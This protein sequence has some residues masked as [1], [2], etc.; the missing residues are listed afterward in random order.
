MKRI[1]SFI[2]CLTM[3]LSFA[4]I[5][6]AERYSKFTD[7]TQDS[8][9]Y[10][11][12]DNAVRLGIINGK[13]ETTF[14]PD[15]NLTY[16]EAIKLA[17]C[18][19]QLY[20]DG[21]VY[22]VSGGN[23]WYE[24]YVNYAKDHGIITDNF[25]EKVNNINEKATRAGYMEIFA[26]A[27]PDEALECIN[28]VPD[29]SIPDVPMVHESAIGIYKL[30]R[31]GILTG[32]DANHNC[33]PEDNIKRC[34]V[35]AII[36]RMMDETKRLTFS[37]GT[38][39]EEP[40]TEEPKAEEPKTEEPKLEIPKDAEF[41]PEIKEDEASIPKAETPDMYEPF[42]IAVQPTHI[43]GADEGDELKYTVKATG[44]KTPYTY[45]WVSRGWHNQTTAINDSE[46]AKGTKTNTLTMIFDIDNLSSSQFR[47]EV[48]DALGQKVQSDYIEL[49]EKIFIFSPE[50]VTSY[51]GG[52]IFAG[53][54]S[55]GS[56]RAGETVAISLPGE[57]IQ[58][59]GVATKLEM[60]K[61]SIDEVEEGNYCGILIQELE[62][63]PFEG[64]IEESYS[65]AMTEYIEGLGNYGVKIP[66]TVVECH[67]PAYTKGKP[68]V[69]Y[70]QVRGGTPPYTYEWYMREGNGEE[71]KVVN[72]A[73][74]TVDGKDL[75]I[76]EDENEY[77]NDVN[78]RCVITDAAGNSE[79][80]RNWRIYSGTTPYI[81]RQPQN[82]YANPGDKVTFKISSR[83]AEPTYQWYVKY[84][85]RT[86]W[87]K[88][89]S[90]DSWASGATTPYLT[91]QVEKTDLINHCEYKCE[92]KQGSY[93]VSSD[94]AKLLPEN[95]LI[96]QQ[97]KNVSAKHG[98]KAQFTVKA[99]GANGPFTYQWLIQTPD[100]EIPLKITDGFPW[101]EG[102]Y[103]DT[104]SVAVD[105]KKLT[106]DYKFSC[107]VTDKNGV[108]RISD[109]AYVIVTSD[110]SVKLEKNYSKKP[111]MIVIIE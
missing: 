104:L 26:S 54:V 59:Y 15:D 23:P 1:L 90:T 31:A 6:H 95:V 20:K 89:D 39:A 32:V 80:I 94:A 25:F 86:T 27:L 4:S 21:S 62:D 102:Q 87:Q 34:E 2:L 77:V 30:Y 13:S 79:E 42:E 106:S 88:I 76:Y 92:V 22:L 71:Q 49:P 57:N 68:C 107:I 48:T 37:M 108:K 5:V 100:N 24:T 103:T 65:E 18:M 74:Y 60:F 73:K 67:V 44:G 110:A 78:Y 101:A 33:K 8:W 28:N 51:N 81:S 82:L 7:V 16:A 46:Y 43:A 70:P 93:G 52:Y 55:K 40:K 99:E 97:P 75:Y 91:I 85:G 63:Y 72:N 105:E 66:L 98:E 9:Y 58:G 36:T 47:C 38:N 111:D 19:Y 61:K 53:R 45:Q 35:A 17:A 14:A 96:T 64:F 10:E 56:L 12:V 84:D 69:I 109:E 50:S 29:A 41:A 11:D 83:G 3:I